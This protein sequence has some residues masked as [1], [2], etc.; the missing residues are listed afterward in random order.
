MDPVI[1][2]RTL[3]EYA[4]YIAK[5]ARTISAWCQENGQPEPTLHSGEGVGFL[6]P[7]APLDLLKTRQELFQATKEVQN[8]IMEPWMFLGDHII[9]VSEVESS[10]SHRV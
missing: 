2:P 4:D 7:S 8:I 6:P 10:F 9:H 1:P 3:V 5:A